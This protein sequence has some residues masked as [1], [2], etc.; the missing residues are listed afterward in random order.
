MTL[1][2]YLTRLVALCIAPLLLLALWLAWAHVEDVQR[3]QRQAAARLARTLAGNVEHALRARLAGLQMLARSPLVD[4]PSRWAELHREAQGY[5]AVFDSHVILVDAERRLRLHTGVPWGEALPALVRP[6]G[7]SAVEQAFETRQAAVG[8]LFDGP[9]ARQPLVAL[10][11]PG[12]RDERAAIVWLAIVPA[13][14]LERMLRETSIEAGWRARM[15]DGRGRVI[16]RL[17]TDDATAGAAPD[18]AWQFVERPAPTSWSVEVTVPR[19]AYMQPMGRIAMALLA[20]LLG[21]TLISVV[22]GA[23]ASRRLAR[24]VRALVADEGHPD[25]SVIDEV[26]QVRQVLDES[27]ARREAAEAE[28]RDS[29]RRYRERLELFAQEVQMRA[30]QLR[31]IFDSASEA[32]LTADESQTIVMANAAAAQVFGCSV[33]QLIGRP[34]ESLVPEPQRAQHRRDVEA[35][36]RDDPGSRTMGR[37][38]DVMALRVDG[39]PM[40]IEAAISHA[41]V[42][43]AHLYTVILRDV[44]ERRAAEAALRDGRERLRTAHQELAES[45]VELQRLLAQQHSAEDRE[46]RRIARELHD[47]LQQVL[48]AIKMDVGAM[49]QELETNPQRLLSLM[50][51]VDD[52]ATAAITSTRRIVNDL[53]PLLLEELG[54]VAALEALAAQFTQRTGI[55]A[56][57]QAQ[58]SG[59]SDDA[60]PVAVAICL[61]RV[62]QEALNNVAKHAQARQVRI[63]LSGQPDGALQLSVID[64]GRGMTAD[65][66][67]K[68][69]SFGLRGMQERVH[70]VG[71]RLAISSR[72][73]HGTTIEVDIDSASIDERNSRPGVLS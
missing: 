26:A 17:G 31:G 52:L 5:Q 60:L 58:Q 40:P 48:A 42:D 61:Y 43:G 53:R 22:A 3:E 20:A 11:V 62:V 39:T 44:T 38:P 27:V 73:G 56:T 69:G 1:Q 51:R 25:A 12:L 66:R 72:A 63:R 32:I 15:V 57:V 4:A 55:V 36:G 18:S 23:L 24:S 65:A 7:R 14:Q 8:D 6:D 28:R 19:L 9:L 47:E 64:D 71:G 2:R 16:A 29:E 37:R 21:M 67:R 41:H 34:L 50:A 30:S 46:R 35:F 10:A 45:H 54:L 49:R 70:A 13:Q 33:A 68:P 59:L